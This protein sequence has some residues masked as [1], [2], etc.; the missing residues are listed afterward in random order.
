MSITAAPRVPFPRAFALSTER[1]TPCNPSDYEQ[2]SHDIL[3]HVPRNPGVRLERTDINSYLTAELKTQL[4]DEL[5][6]WL[7]FVARKSS[8]S[9]DALH[10]QVVK[11]RTILPSEDP[12]LHLV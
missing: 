1:L 8:N 5:Y 6:N 2:S 12:R 7:W 3:S 11:G 10:V 9:I 4:L